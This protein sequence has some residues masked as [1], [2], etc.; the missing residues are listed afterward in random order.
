[1]LRLQLPASPYNREI[2]ARSDDLDLMKRTYHISITANQIA[3]AALVGLLTGVAVT[4]PALS[5]PAPSVVLPDQIRSLNIPPQ[6]I[7]TVPS[8]YNPNISGLLVVNTPIGPTCIA[9]RDT[10]TQQFRLLGSNCPTGLTYEK[11]RQLDSGL[12][13]DPLTA[14]SDVASFKEDSNGKVT[15]FNRREAGLPCQ[16][17]QFQRVV[18]AIKH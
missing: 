2:Q 7:P 12:L 5:A 15:F 11:L 1:L 4:S 3:Q 16:D 9:S 10:V 18:P 8:S 14:C 6:P 13:A 17:N